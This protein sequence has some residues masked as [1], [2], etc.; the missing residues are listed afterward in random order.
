MM[1]KHKANHIQVVYADS[2]SNALDA[3][4]AKG[5]AATQLGMEVSVCGVQP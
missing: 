3:M 2:R 5:I 4:Y 1:A